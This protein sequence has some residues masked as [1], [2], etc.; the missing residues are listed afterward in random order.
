M[1]TIEQK[2]ENSKITKILDISFMR[3]TVLPELP[4][5]L[6][7]FMNSQNSVLRN[8]DLFCMEFQ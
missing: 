2:I 3:L 6:I 7:N 8:P 1:N 5:T 4:E